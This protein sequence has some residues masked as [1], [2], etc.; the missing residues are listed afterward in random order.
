VTASRERSIELMFAIAQPEY[1]SMM[2][3][4]GKRGKPLPIH[5]TTDAHHCRC[6]LGISHKW[7]QGEGR[8]KS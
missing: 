8:P 2:C 5:I 4:R 6:T 1:I 3:S 7:A